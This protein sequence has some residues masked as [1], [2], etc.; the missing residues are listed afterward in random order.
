M[1][2][3]DG[4]SVPISINLVEWYEERFSYVIISNTGICKKKT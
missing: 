4:V 1:R 3:R 2:Q